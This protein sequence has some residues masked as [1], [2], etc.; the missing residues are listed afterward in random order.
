MSVKIRLA[1]TGCKKRPVYF[2]VAQDTRCPRD[3]RFLEKMG[4]Y[5][6][7]NEPELINIR[8][9]RINAWLDKGALNCSALD[10][11]KILW[12]NL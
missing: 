8:I 12:K 5:D 1:R 9:D 10:Q 2:L 11:G 4:T 3:G 6:P 7:R